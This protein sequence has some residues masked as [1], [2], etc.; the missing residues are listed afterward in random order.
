MISFLFLCVYFCIL[1]FVWDVSISIAEPKK[2]PFFK[3]PVDD[4]C[5]SLDTNID[6]GMQIDMIK[7]LES[8]PENQQQQD[9][10]IIDLENLTAVPVIRS[11]QILGV[12]KSQLIPGT[13][14]F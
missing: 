1:C 13:I 5:N 10:V 14:F 6:T 8:N 2:L 3:I 9:D 4:L 12:R 7:L 11:T